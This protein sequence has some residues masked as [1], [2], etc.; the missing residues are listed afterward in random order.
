MAEAE[1]VRKMVRNGALLKI[2]G[3]VPIKIPCSFGGY[4][5]WTTENRKE[6]QHRRAEWSGWNLW[7]NGPA[8]R[9]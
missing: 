6:C 5:H 4:G 2:T 1:R 9:S 7:M 3:G 8:G